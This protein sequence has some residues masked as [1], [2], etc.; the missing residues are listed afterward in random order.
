MQDYALIGAAA[1]GAGVPGRIA[2]IGPMRM[3]YKRVISAV[4]HVARLF[5]HL[6]DVN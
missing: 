4:A 5:R 6:S 2:V 1:N 3:P